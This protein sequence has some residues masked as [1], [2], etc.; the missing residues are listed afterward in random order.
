MDVGGRMRLKSLVGFAAIVVALWIL[1][2][3]NQNRFHADVR[4]LCI[5]HASD[6]PVVTKVEMTTCAC[7]AD[8]AVSALPWKSRL[9][10]TMIALDRDDNARMLQAQQVC[11]PKVTES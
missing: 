8:A 7:M 2:G 6:G 11:M 4:M 5:G 10:Q 9:P 1:S 3:V